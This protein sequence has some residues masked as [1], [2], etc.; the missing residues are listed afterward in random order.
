MTHGALVVIGSGPGI[1]V[2]TATHFASKGF[3]HIVLLSR[4]TE[5]LSEDAA[6]VTKVASDTKVETI[7]IDLADT[8]SRVKETLAKVDAKLKEWNTELEVVLFNAARVGMS[9]PLE[10]TAD[11]LANDLK[12]GT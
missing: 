11:E 6:A 12:V 10:W 5:R 7:T 9:K 2:T 4:N 3:K 8:E 1:G